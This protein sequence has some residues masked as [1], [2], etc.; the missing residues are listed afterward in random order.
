MLCVVLGRESKLP[1]EYSKVLLLRPLQI[2]YSTSC[3]TRLSQSRSTYS[4]ETL[5]VVSIQTFLASAPSTVLASARSNLHRMTA[6]SP[7]ANLVLVVTGY[8]TLLQR[9]AFRL[10]V[11]AQALAQ[12]KTRVWVVTFY[13]KFSCVKWLTMFWTITFDTRQMRL[14]MTSKQL[15]CSCLI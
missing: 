11:T 1:L 15:F 8:F 13:L 5:P 3:A 7:F 12:V 4:F 9:L 10:R 14:L 6:G 2:A